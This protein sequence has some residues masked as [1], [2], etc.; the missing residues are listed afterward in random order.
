M[1]KITL[2]C[3][4]YGYAAAATLGIN[5]SFPSVLEYT[6]CSYQR[7]LHDV[8]LSY[9]ESNF[10]ECSHVEQILLHASLMQKVHDLIALGKTQ[11]THRPMAERTY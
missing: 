9:D 11:G 1:T 7:V 2:L 10:H 8:Q 6:A 5:A 3:A 4:K